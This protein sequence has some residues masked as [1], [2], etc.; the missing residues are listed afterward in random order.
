MARKDVR[1]HVL[2]LL[3]QPRP[4]SRLV[5]ASQQSHVLVQSRRNSA[6]A[7]FFSPQ[8]H[9]CAIYS[10]CRHYVGWRHEESSREKRAVLRQTSAKK[11]AERELAEGEQR[12]GGLE[13]CMRGRRL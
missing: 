3:F 1:K 4:S 2:P 10:V 7:L 13:D 9:A 5:L 12:S 11:Q 6:A 8:C